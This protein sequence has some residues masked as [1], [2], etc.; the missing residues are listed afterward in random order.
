MIDMPQREIKFRAWFKDKK[1]MREVAMLR[2]EYGRM[3]RIAGYNLDTNHNGWT[4]YDP[5]SGKIEL[6]QFTGLFDKNGKEIYEGDI[7]QWGM[8]GLERE[9]RIAVVE[10][11]PDI[12]FRR[13]NGPKD[14]TDYEFVFQY[15][16]FAYS[17]EIDKVMEV[18]GNIHESPEKLK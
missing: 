9:V 2:W 18:I 5:E 11:D 1:E 17:H 14:G 10:I 12:Q 3:S 7:V 16:R 4:D 8:G 15:G 13:I 6:M